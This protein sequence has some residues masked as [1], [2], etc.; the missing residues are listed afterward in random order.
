MKKSHR[1]L[2]LPP[3]L[4]SLYKSLSLHNSFG[5]ITR[6]MGWKQ[7][8]HL[9]SI[10][11]CSPAAYITRLLWF[12]FRLLQITTYVPQWPLTFLSLNRFW[13]SYL[14]AD[15]YKLLRANE[16]IVRKSIFSDF[17]LVRS[18]LFEIEKKTKTFLHVRIHT[19]SFPHF[20]YFFVQRRKLIF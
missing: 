12:W 11:L 9:L 20:W 5:I 15:L 16:L 7:I 8:N 6:R 4:C 10:W 3:S 18:C 19:F 14:Y 1:M 13:G 2:S 17:L